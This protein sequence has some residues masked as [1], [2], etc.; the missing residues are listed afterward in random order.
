MF[1]N[2]YATFFF[3]TLDPTTRELRYVNAGHNPPMLVRSGS[4]DLIRLEAGGMVV[5]L[6]PQVTYEAQSV[7]MN[8]GDLLICYTD[9]I[10]EAMSVLEEEWGEE[11]MLDAAK[12]VPVSSASEVLHSIFQAADEFTGEAPQHDDMTLL[13]VQI[14]SR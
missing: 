14:S 13:I 11:R 12:S 9:G 7:T 3:A 2:R 4:G 5:G 6:L 10:S 8:S 1:L